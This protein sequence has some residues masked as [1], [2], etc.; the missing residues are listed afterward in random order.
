MFNDKSTQLARNL[1]LF[2]AVLFNGRKTKAI[3][4]QR[5]FVVVDE[6]F[7]PANNFNVKAILK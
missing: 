7:L 3:H 4:I 2:K 5:P 6:T 1:V